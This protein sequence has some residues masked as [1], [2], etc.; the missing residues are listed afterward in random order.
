MNILF[1]CTGNTCRSPMAEAISRKLIR[2]NP[3]RYGN[4]RVASAGIAAEDGGEM[5][6]EAKN[7]LAEKD[8][9]YSQFQSQNIYEELMEQAD[10]VL[11]MGQSHK[12]LLS[13]YNKEW[14]DKIFTI[15]EYVGDQAEI[16]D[17][18]GGDK[19][20]YLACFEELEVKIKDIFNKLT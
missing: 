8:C 18:F 16:A 14:Q 2:E 11:T 15:G 20:E 5:S 19:E 1:V 4:I 10:L 3:M 6:E 17:P 9:T 12:M 7:V 13:A